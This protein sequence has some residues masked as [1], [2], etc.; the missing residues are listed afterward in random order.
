MRPTSSASLASFT[1]QMMWVAA[2]FGAPIDPRW[3]VPEQG[4]RGRPGRAPT[5]AATSAVRSLAAAEGR[6]PCRPLPGS[7]ISA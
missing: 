1:R 7:T 6:T 3:P 2:A 4:S 5:R